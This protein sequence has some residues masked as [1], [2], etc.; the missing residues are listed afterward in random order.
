VCSTLRPNNW[1]HLKASTWRQQDRPSKTSVPKIYPRLPMVYGTRRLRSE[2]FGYD[3]CSHS[4]TS[5][6]VLPRELLAASK[7]TPFTALAMAN[8][9]NPAHSFCG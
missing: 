7:R 3:V 6:V 2:P 4:G 1:M 8:A 9:P 5:K